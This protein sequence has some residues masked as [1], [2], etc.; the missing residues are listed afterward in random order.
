[1]SAIAC[2]M[3]PTLLMVAIVIITGHV[4]KS[5]Y[6]CEWEARSIYYQLGFVTPVVNIGGCGCTLEEWHG[7][8]IGLAMVLASIPCMLF[9]IIITCLFIHFY[10]HRK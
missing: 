5:K 6:K 7:Q 3:I 4:L 8:G 10:K 1:M 9:I 2:I